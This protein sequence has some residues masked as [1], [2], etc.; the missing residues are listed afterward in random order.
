[1]IRRVSLA[2]ALALAAVTTVA[3]SNPTAPTPDKV[4]KVR[5]DVGGDTLLLVKVGVQG[6]SI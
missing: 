2:L 1:V 4:A 5:A 6:S 3:C